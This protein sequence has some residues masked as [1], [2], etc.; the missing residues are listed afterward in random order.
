MRS[1]SLEEQEATAEEPELPAPPARNDSPNVQRPPQDS[2]VS[3][4]RKNLK[5]VSP[6]APPPP[7]RPVFSPT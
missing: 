2:G 5:A 1:L 6:S 7:I 3:N 4:L